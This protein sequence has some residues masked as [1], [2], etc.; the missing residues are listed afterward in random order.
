MKKN[1]AH[2]VYHVMVVVLSAALAL[3]LPDVVKYLAR[4]IL[5]YWT[6][7]E[8][9][10][11]F[12]V[13]TEIAAAVAL[14][15]LINT[16]VRSWGIRK[17]SW[18]ARISGLVRVVPAR[19]LL[20]KRR[21]KKLKEE[22]GSGRNVMIISSTGYR[23]MVEPTGDL[24]QVLLNCREA[25]I[26]LLNPLK[27]GVTARA[28]S[29]ADPDITPE[30]FR[31]QIIRS[32]DFIKGLRM[33]QKN[34]RLKLYREVPL[35]KL[36]ILGDYLC[37]QHYPSGRNVRSMPEYVFKHDRD[38]NL[39]GLFYQYFV[40]RWLDPAIPEYDLDTDDLVYRDKS[41]N[42]VKREQFNEVLME[43]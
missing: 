30:S 18:M 4:K 12:L 22:Q 42:E 38:Q 11:L 1:A 34:I 31:E 14:I 21:L 28:R 24:H 2:I 9:E 10:E 16:I 7:I 3:S 35:L 5:L 39:F 27:D 8:N 40:T 15:V 19:S 13:T 41:G 6:F 25:K 20:A 37:L 33:H 17:R 43:Y 32:I 26:M 29:L 23:T 36:A